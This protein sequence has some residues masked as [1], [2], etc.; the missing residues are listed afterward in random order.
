MGA[1][2][3]RVVIGVFASGSSADYAAAMHMPRGLAQ[4]AFVFET[5]A[6]VCTAVSDGIASHLHG[7]PKTAR[8]NYLVIRAG[9]RYIALD[10]TGQMSTVYSVGQAFDDVRISLR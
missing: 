10:P 6:A 8:G 3:A 7:G 9:N 2:H 1:Q 4:A 5:D